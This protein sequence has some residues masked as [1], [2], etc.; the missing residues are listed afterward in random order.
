[1]CS[2]DLLGE[3]APATRVAQL[4]ALGDTYSGLVRTEVFR[5]QKLHRMRGHNRD[6]EPGS[7]AQGGLH[8]RLVAIGAAALQLD[9]I[10]VAVLLFPL[11]SP[12]QRLVIT[13]G[14]KHL[15]DIAVAAARKNDQAFV[16]GEPFAT[17]FRTTAV[18]IVE[19]GARQEI[20][21]RKIARM[22]TR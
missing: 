17:D 11:C 15:T 5:Q 20:A 13:T 14:F 19:P 4:L 16:L 10:V 12:R 18:L 7:Q 9:E 1:V 8:I 2:S 22:V 21:H 3:T 6:I